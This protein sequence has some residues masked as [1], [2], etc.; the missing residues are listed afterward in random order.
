MVEASA[1]EILWTFIELWNTR[2]S[3]ET[4]THS[5]FLELK[6]YSVVPQN[7]AI[8]SIDTDYDLENI[9][10]IPQVKLRFVKD[11]SK[12]VRFNFSIFGEKSGLG[13]RISASPI[14]ILIKAGETKL[15]Y[16]FNKEDDF[17]FI[18]IQPNG[19]LLIVTF[20]S[21]PSFQPILEK[22]AE[23][24]GEIP[25]YPAKPIEKLFTLHTKGL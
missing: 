3:K 16:L 13:G 25:K 17:E 1:S 5:S 2:E 4:E 10:P 12:M 11:A 7:H 14:E 6:L 23:L 24:Y 19:V 9:L 8:I 22:L 18:F 20:H 15:M 21:E